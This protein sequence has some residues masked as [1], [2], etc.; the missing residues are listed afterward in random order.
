MG[1]KIVKLK[2]KLEG[3][4][5]LPFEQDG[6]TYNLYDMPKGFVIK[7]SL[8]L[9]GKGLTE[10]PD[11]SALKV[12]GDF[13]CS[14]N[15]LTSLKGTPQEVGGGFYC[16][17]NQLTTLEE[18]P[19]FVGGS[20]VCSDNQLT[21]LKGAPNDI[22]GIFDCYHNQLTTLEGAPNEVGGYF[23]C[24]GNR[25]TSL[26]GGP[27]RV[28]GEFD[29]DWN[30]LTTLK[31]APQEVSGDFKCYHNKLTSLLGIP[32]LNSDNKIVCDHA[33]AKKYGSF[34]SESSFCADIL[35]ENL[36]ESALYKSEVG[37]ANIRRKLSKEPEEM[38]EEEKRLQEK[39]VQDK[40]AVR[41][42]FDA[43][44]EENGNK[45]K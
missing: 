45:Q 5:Y 14:F 17:N 20:F 3:K 13:N 40:K 42:A 31:G 37:A 12:E 26:E 29:C 9:S 33:L 25:L 24:H 41:A 28:D 18:A 38:T 8:N 35:Y 39:S 11:L 44:L 21:T 16:Q 4:K 15:L 6:K 22:A 36:I 23:D 10:L 32:V 7:G 30:E 43:W 19:E 1:L 2:A 34:Y 27:Q